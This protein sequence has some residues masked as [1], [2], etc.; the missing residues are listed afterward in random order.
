MKTPAK[1]SGKG[2][3]LWLLPLPLVLWLAAILAQSWAPGVKLGGLLD[4]LTASLDNPLALQWTERT[5]PVCLVAILL[6]FGIIAYNKSMTANTRQG[7]EHGSA[8]WGSPAQLNAKYA[9]HKNPFDN[10]ILTQNVRMGTDTHKHRRNLNLL[11]V[12]GSGSGKSR[13][14]AMPALLQAA[15]D[16]EN[17]NACSYLIT[18]PKAELLRTIGPLL[19]A[20]GYEIKVFNL[21][22]MAQSDAFNPFP[23]MRSE[24]D[25]LKLINNLVKNTT[26]KNAKGE[27]PFW[28][29]SEIALLSALILYLYHEAPAYEQNFSTVMYMLENAAA[30]EENEEYR[31]P[32]DLVFN[33]LEDEQ[34]EHIAVKQY[35]VFKQAAGKTAKSILV[36]AAVRLAAFNL[37]E[38]R[39]MT[40]Y[41]DM[42]LGS[43]GE[44]K[45]AIFCVI[46]DNGDTSFNY[47]VGML[48]TCAFQELYYRADQLHDGVLPVPVRI[49]MDEFQNVPVP[50]GSDFGKI[51]ATCRSR[52][53]FCNIIIQNMAALRAMF[54]KDWENITGNCDSML[55]LGGNEQSTH[56]YVSKLL[57]KST[58]D[59]KTRGITRGRSGSSSENFQHSGRELMQPDEVRMLDNDFAL[60]FIRGER[61]VLDRKFDLI[62]HPHIHLTAHGGA[63]PYRIATKGYRRPDLSEPFTSLDDI[64]II[65]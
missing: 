47:I 11:V 27:D 2:W 5:A 44:R 37:E 17:P 7:E 4:N 59:T 26:P 45:R 58:I 29:K 6:Y 60:L 55:Y 41:D 31:S 24:A 3:L 19:A 1:A 38:V 39:R 14:V 21:V 57:G 18:D 65:E 46:P 49:I 36:S 16:S 32:I 23:Y 63:E 40:D 51:L 13:A 22:N 61:P 48:Y 64:E 53:I 10:I 9:N 30:S 54:D 56:E 15:T 33:G 12:G 28:E 8:Q 34:P 43:L 42:D 20:K 52:Q 35:K 62:R 50:G 25:V